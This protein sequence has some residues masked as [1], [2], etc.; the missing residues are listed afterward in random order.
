M[1]TTAEVARALGVSRRRVSELVRTGMLAGT[2]LSSRDWLISATAL[3][4]Y[5]ARTT[6]A[7]RPWNQDQ[8]WEL[9]LCLSDSTRPA[10]DWVA[11]RIRSNS[12]ATIGAQVGR[13]TRA[14]RLETRL[15]EDKSSLLALTGAS[16]I[17]RL[18]PTLT[19]RSRVTH[20]YTSSMDFEADFDA[21]RFDEGNLCLRTW[22]D[23]KPRF[24]NPTPAA[25]VAIDA[26]NDPDA[27]VRSAGLKLLEEMRSHWLAAN[28][29]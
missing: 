29:Q 28:G 15:I 1:H 7:G 5:S 20:A 24:T 11:E 18:D 26:M 23:R 22:L 27:R 8:A 25:L 16:A 12:A 6:Q 17:G 4:E 3:A 10:T 13:L 9:V 19:G 2:L 21:V 14:T